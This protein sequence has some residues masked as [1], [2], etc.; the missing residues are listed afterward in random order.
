MGGFAGG[1]EGGLAADEWI[2]REEEPGG[3]GCRVCC[4]AIVGVEG[5]N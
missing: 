4:S 5:G 3:V 2:G 1:W